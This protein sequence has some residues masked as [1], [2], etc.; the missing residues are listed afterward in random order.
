[1]TSF[2]GMRRLFESKVMWQQAKND[3]CLHFGELGK[4][5]HPGKRCL[6][7]AGGSIPNEQMCD[8]VPRR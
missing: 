4:K 2:G 8:S 7:L 6:C 3:P 1:M 5:V